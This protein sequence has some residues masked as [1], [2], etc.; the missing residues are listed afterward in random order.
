MT[1]K[2]T[3]SQSKYIKSLQQKKYR[4]LNGQ[5]LVEGVKLMQEAIDTGF[6]LDFIAFTGREADYD[7]DFPVPAFQLSPKELS[8]IS[9]LKSPNRILAVCNIPKVEPSL[10]PEFPAIA[11]DAISDPGNLGT[12]VRLADWFGI[13][14]IFCSPDSVD[15]FNPK[16]VQATMGSIF[17]LR[18]VYTDLEVLI[19]GLPANFPTYLADM[20]GKSIYDIAIAAPYF[21]LMGSESHGA[22]DTLK[23]LVSTKV[24]IP[25]SGQGESLNV[26][27]STG[28]I[29]SEFKR[30]LSS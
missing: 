2:L 17:R 23:A 26:A 29:L 10:D 14:Q 8:Q 6:P 25:K 16:V 3:K 27:M 19:R 15:C 9:A 28:I 1:G 21:L 5:F 13:T 18:L 12:I 20:D 30:K 7:F 4:D 11:L 22:S 24:S